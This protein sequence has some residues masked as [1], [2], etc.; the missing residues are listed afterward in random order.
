MKPAT[1]LLMLLLFTL[2]ATSVAGDGLTLARDGHSDYL[3]VLPTKPSSV[4]A[5]AADELR[6]H[7]QKVTG[8]KLEILNENRARP[9]RKAILVGATERMKRLLPEVS[10]TSL[11]ADGIVM[12]TVDGDL[13]LAGHPKRGT[14]YAVYTF[15]E[16]VV[17]CRWWTAEESFTP[18]RPT[19]EIPALDVVYAPKLKVREAFYLNAFDGVFSAR[20]KCNGHFN[21]VA[22]QYGG[23][24]RFAGFVHTFYPLLPPEKYFKEH[25]EWYS[26]IGG[27]R[28]HHRG[29]LCLT[30]E[31]MRRELVRNALALLRE[32]PGAGMI[33]ISQ[34]DWRGN[35]QCEKCKAI[36]EEEGAPSGLMIRFVNAVAEQIEK[37]FPNVLVETLAYQY[38]RKPP[39]HARPRGSVV[40]RLCSIECSFVQPLADG[41]QNEKFRGDIESWSRIAPRLYVWDYVT[42]FCNYILPH[43]NLPVLAPNIRFFV[44]HKVM[45]LFEQGD[46]GS[47]IGDFVRLRAWLVAHLMWNPDQDENR[48]ISEFLEGYYGAAAPHLLA[49][50]NT[51]NEA[52]RRSGVY[53]RCFMNGTSGWLSLDDLNTATRHFNKA[54]AAVAD[55]P[56]L[57]RRVRRERMPLD[58]VWLRRYRSLKQIAQKEKKEFLG[59]TDPVVA[60]REFIDLAHRHKV[61]QWRERV[62]FSAYENQLRQLSRPAELKRGQK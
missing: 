55:D 25:P 29:Q 42:N 40:V 60:C 48:L 56:V 30:N 58:H 10:L 12:K 46:Y 38:T 32:S 51:I 39:R 17:G 24:E 43:P 53:L 15:L 28:T 16:D 33:S 31:E 19:L 35:C 8:A 9:D 34:N 59:P 26:L 52:G 4:E 57:L 14:L 5:T 27:K 49:Y 62:P 1:N 20:C 23:H 6:G 3:I 44:D 61:G 41:P 2:A 45:A 11:G 47:S 21:R 36:E 37:E 18:N 22:K 13:V 50:L 54:M 7:L